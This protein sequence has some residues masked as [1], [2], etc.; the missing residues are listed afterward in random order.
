MLED[1]DNALNEL[2]PE[3]Y[4]YGKLMSRRLWKMGEKLAFCEF[5]WRYHPF[6]ISDSAVSRYLRD[7]ADAKKAL[8]DFLGGE[9]ISLPLKE[10][11]FLAWLDPEQLEECQV[12]AFSAALDA[13][14]RRRKVPP[15][16]VQFVWKI[17]PLL[18]DGKILRE[19]I[20]IVA[21]DVQGDDK[22]AYAI[23]SQ[24][25][26]IG[27]V[28]RKILQIYQP[29]LADSCYGCYGRTLYL[30]GEQPLSD[31]EIDVVIE[32]ISLYSN[33]KAAGTLVISTDPVD[34]A[35]CSVSTASSWKT[36]YAPGGC[37]E[38][39]P[40][41]FMLDG[42]TA[43]CYAY[44]DIGDTGLPVK[45]WRAW[46]H[47]DPERGAVLGRQ[48]PAEKPA[49]M[50][51]VA[52]LLQKIAG[53]GYETTSLPRDFYEDSPSALVYGGDNI[54]A[55][56][57]KSP[58]VTPGADYFYCLG[59][60]ACVDAEEVDHR[61]HARVLCQDCAED[62]PLT[63]ERCGGIV[64]LDDY[65]EINGCYYCDSACAEAAGWRLCDQCYE[66][67][68]VEDAIEY[69]GRVYC[70]EYCAANAGLVQCDYCGE[71][72]HEDD[73]IDTG[74]AGFCSAYCAKAE[75]Y[76]ECDSCGDWFREDDM[77]EVSGH[78]YCPDCI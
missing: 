27:K 54:T 46:L 74:D 7:T 44:K 38:T 29:S 69:C 16:A 49:Y 50:L 76:R 70:S 77:T 61:E 75:G 2:V 25:Q 62:E 51:A 32:M 10:P 8:V 42:C 41:S 67:F 78:Y 60:G 53:W 31:E 33:A 63:C 35:A 59:C 18:Q 52:Y 57:G 3:G 45:L 71:W 24:G 26:K 23:I 43:I 28:I 19:D 55:V 34:I 65:I 4:Y 15:G 40:Y 6:S 21:L 22:P 73:I 14:T 64:D 1:L 58:W 9:K 17:F 36:C 30:H 5:L 48:Y 12:E 11:G 37:Y 47:I 56:F 20:K 66:W 72:T 68:P 39:A 13:Y